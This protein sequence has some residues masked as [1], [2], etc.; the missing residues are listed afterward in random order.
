MRLVRLER[1][2]EYILAL[3]TTCAII[4]WHLMIGG[5]IMAITIL[6]DDDPMSQATFQ[7]AYDGPAMR[8]H[9]MD[10]QQLGP[11]LLSVGDL[12]REAN[13]VING[14][15]AAKVNV[16]VRANFEE[17]CFD[18]TFDLI[19]WF[20]EVKDLMK[21]D[22]AADAKL[23]LEW[24]GLIGGGTTGAY[25][26]LQ[27]LKWKRGKKIQSVQENKSVEGATNYNI[28][29]EGDGNSVEISSQVYDLFR[30]PRVRA[31]QR[32]VV[33]PLRDEGVDFV[34]VR[35]NGEPITRL[36]RDEYEDGA[37]EIIESE[38]SQ[39]EALEPQAFDAI[40]VIRAPVF[41]EGNK[42]QFWLGETRISASINDDSF[43]H[44]VFVR[45][46]KFG[47]G[48]RLKVKMSLTQVLTSKGK[49][50]N[51]YEIMDVIEIMHG[52]V[53]LDFLEENG[54]ND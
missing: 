31:A 16:K 12:C 41:V 23:L 11:A 27:F 36:T 9:S 39:E 44:R 13:R 29:I 53:Q 51:E 43:N 24:I 19:Q 7:I 46:E 50:R 18:I 33:A 52:P 42:W 3:A 4:Q 48:D 28:T 34:E 32:G 2:V 45:G 38:V 37:Y 5:K 40:L 8:G 47:V 54:I 25:G 10:V 20:Q 26:L 6:R 17:R 49:Y 22:E 35:E 1:T 30:S 15:D 14:E 21:A